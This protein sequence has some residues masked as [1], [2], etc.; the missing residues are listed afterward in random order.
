MVVYTVP[1]KSIKPRACGV[2][3]A[4]RPGRRKGGLNGFIFVLGDILDDDFELLNVGRAVNGVE[5]PCIQ[6]V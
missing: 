4:A 5:A 3:S 1:E 6:A 2:R